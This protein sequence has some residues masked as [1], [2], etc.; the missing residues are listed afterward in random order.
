MHWPPADTCDGGHDWILQE[1]REIAVYTLDGK[2]TGKTITLAGSVFDI[3]IRKDIVHRVVRWQVRTLAFPS[4]PCEE[5]LSPSR[6]GRDV[7][8]AA[9]HSM[10]NHGR[11]SPVAAP[12][13]LDPRS[14]VCSL[15]RGNRGRTRRRTAQRCAGCHHCWLTSAQPTRRSAAL[16]LVCVDC[17]KEPLFAPQVSGTGKKPHQQK[18]TGA[19]RQV[20]AA[21]LTCTARTPRPRSRCARLTLDLPPPAGDEARPAPQGRR[22]RPREGG[23]QPRP[24]PAAQ[25]APL[26]SS[27]QPASVAAALPLCSP[28]ARCLKRLP[29]PPEFPQVRKLG[30]KC[31]LSAKVAEGN[32]IVVDEAAVEAPKTKALVEKLEGAGLKPFC[33]ADVRALPTTTWVTRTPPTQASPSRAAWIR[34]SSSA[35]RF[36]SLMARR[37]PAANSFLR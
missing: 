24:R 8:I 20:G 16:R 21:C 37:F 35:S 14:V 13:R 17:D 3:P 19:A 5:A 36:S 32:L 12:D 1:D 29:R 4:E 15:Q 11:R 10:H 26:G 7:R 33:S 23:P 25:G 31:A 28:S 30:L 18:G 27:A 22:P 34:R 2:P 9:A 6:A